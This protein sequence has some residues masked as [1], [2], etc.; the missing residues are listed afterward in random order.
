M[1]LAI[2][3]LEESDF[4]AIHPLILE[5]AGLAREA[6]ALQA[7]VLKACLLVDTNFALV[8][9]DEGK[10]IG[11]AS[12]LMEQET[13]Q[14]V[15]G[16]LGRLC[17]TSTESRPAV[18]AN[19]V[20][21]ALQS[22]SDNMQ[23]CFAEVLVHEVWAQAACE[24][25]G[26]VAS[27]FLPHKFHG[28]P[29]PG[30][31][32]YLFLSE[33]ARNLRR[34]HPELIPGASNLAVEVLKAHGL[35]EDVEVREDAVAYPTECDLTFSPIESGAVQTMLESHTTHDHEVFHLLQ[36]THTCLHLPTN[37]VVYMAAKD[38]ER[39]VGVIGYLLDPVDRRV[40]ITDLVALDEEPEG[41]LLVQ[42]MDALTR[43]HAPEYWE[44]LV[45]AHAPRMQKTFDQVGFVP[46][47]Y[48]PA[49]VTEHGARTDAVKMVKLN[50]SYE[51]ETTELTSASRGMF[52]LI[53]TI[54]R[55][56]SVGMAVIKLLRDLRIFQNMGD[57]ELRRVARL[58]SQKLFRP[59]E[60][61][62][63]E[64][65]S[66]CE[67]YVVERGEIEIVTGDKLLGTLRNGAVLGEIA[68][69]NGE[70][71]TARAVSKTATIVR[72]IHRSDFDRLIQRESHLGLIF[73]QNMALD[74]ADK[75]KNSVA[76][77]KAKQ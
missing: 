47:A 65:T 40:Q 60:V 2:R 62:F 63:N 42:L 49:F 21:T 58:F 29:R 19:L 32:C 36:K 5:K 9:E 72:V 57:G 39:V 33:Q 54:F 16:L 10:I 51:S 13:P 37:D 69:L 55:E 66:G 56:H 27:G 59:G 23:F 3:N 43:E 41:F 53:D 11:T 24:E 7:D 48:F 31:V 61:I 20:A 52:T 50:T 17:V 70:T 46:C 74:L 67:I 25:S 30:A 76:Q 6:P 12:I 71:R 34:P 75:L 18:A 73:F 22:L 8:G 35:I 26:F 45:S 77:A 28:E 15:I 44:A 68:F 64:G 38:G 4:A 1:S 14:T